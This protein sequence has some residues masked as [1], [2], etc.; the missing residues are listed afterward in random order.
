[1]Q[2][3]QF[4]T[5]LDADLARL[6]LESEGIRHAHVIEHAS[7][8]PA[9]TDPM[10]GV[11]IQVLAEDEERARAILEQ[12]LVEG[13][14]VGSYREG[15]IVPEEEPKDIIRC[16]QCELEYCFHGRPRVLHNVPQIGPLGLVMAL[17]VMTVMVLARVFG[18]KRWRCEKCGHVWDD[19]ADC[20][21]EMTPADPADPRPVF[22]LQR[23]HP[24]TG[25]TLGGITGFVAALMLSFQHSSLTISAC[26]LVGLGIG[27]MF[28]YDVCSEPTCRKRLKPGDEMCEA[29]KGH[30]AGK[31]T[32]AKEHFSEAAAFRR[33]LAHALVE[34][35]VKR[36][37][38]KP[39]RLPA[40]SR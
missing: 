6:R 33:E 32:I 15:A 27:S 17:P 20:P 2:V 8:N 24:G 18:P 13:H 35:R 1:M 28:T 23:A 31:I 5:R 7:F 16:P 36:K 9:L 21:R 25:A 10:G 38:S 37:R 3:G 19:L 26:V 40:D 12:P 34:P 29:C 4:S 22:R 39:R 14:H 11:R 30:I